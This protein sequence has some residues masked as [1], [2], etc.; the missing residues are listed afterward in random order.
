MKK[1]FNSFQLKCMTIGMMIVGIYL[2]QIVYLLN[3][4]LITGGGTLP[5][6]QS[7]LY[8][9]GYVLYLAAFP[10]A[11]FL[12]VEAVRNTS[13]KKKLF[14][15][16]LATALLVEIPMDIATFGLSEWKNWGLNQNFFF[17]LVIGVCVL[18]AVEAL[19]KKYAQGSLGNNLV[20]LGVYLLA[21]LAAILLRSEQGSV[22]VLT[23]ICL[24]LF[25][26]N[27]MFSLVSV[28]ALYLLFMGSIGGLAYLPPLSILLV[29]M[30]NGE[31]GKAGKVTRIVFYAA[32]PV[33]Y[34]ALGI[35]A[36]VL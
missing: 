10:L 26:G 33:A 34:F 16:L 27:R 5:Q 22:G 4:E 7:L 29:W 30:Y 17:T 2:Q 24:Y 21:A 23:V 31:Q 32:F 18:I 25:Y 20:S 19:A 1:I 8:H 36:Q 9:V 28:A 6:V 3:E 35:M 12:L 11:A 14:L 15:R 13:D